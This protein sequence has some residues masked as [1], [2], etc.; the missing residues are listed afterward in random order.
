MDA[1][2]AV[3]ATGVGFLAWALVSGISWLLLKQ[4]TE[5]GQPHDVAMPGF[6]EAIQ[7]VSNYAG[8][9]IDIIGLAAMCA[10]MVLIFLAHRQ[11]ISISW[12]WLVLCGQLI[13]ALLGAVFVITAMLGPQGVDSSEMGLAEILS[14]ISLPV[15]IVTAVIVWS[16]FAFYMFRQAPETRRRRKLSRD[17]G[18]KSNWK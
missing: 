8:Y 15:V 11:V 3:I 10:C 4:Q 14:M 17:D 1:A 13:F 7:S 6:L 2:L 5:N 16:V 18:V 9:A 12:A